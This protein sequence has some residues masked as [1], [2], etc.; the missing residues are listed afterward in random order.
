MRGILDREDTI[1]L[2]F[3]DVFSVCREAAFSA[4]NTRNRNVTVQ[5]QPAPA[6]AFARMR[7]GQCSA[8][9]RFKLAT[10]SSKDCAT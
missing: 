3:L 7:L 9:S 5:L 6:A 10:E 2:R 8:V 1:N 4:N